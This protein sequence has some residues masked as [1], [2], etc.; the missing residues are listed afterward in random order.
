MEDPLSTNVTPP[1]AP[2]VTTV[3][4]K[5][6]GIAHHRM[7]VVGVI[8]AIILLV[9]GFLFLRNY[10]NSRAAAGIQSNSNA[11]GTEEKIPNE[12][13]LPI[14]ED[15]T[16]DTDMDGISDIEEETIGT[17]DR[18]FDSD[19]DGLSDLNERSVWK[20]NPTN[21]DSDGDGFFDG[22]EV[23]NGYNPLGEGSL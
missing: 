1:P 8:I 19:G 7:V 21:P 10:L 12:L 23:F 17:T 6:P 5:E 16:H 9:I 3:S 14:I 2:T 20:T 15:T 22:V 13:D 4:V 18:D 11:V